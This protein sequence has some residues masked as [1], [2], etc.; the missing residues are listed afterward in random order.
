MKREEIKT[1]KD[2]CKVIGRK[3]RTYKDKHLNLYEQLSTI[4]AALN[5]I[6]NDNKPWTP[7]FDYYY[8]YSW[9]Y[10]EDEYN[11]T[12]GLFY[13]VSRDRLGSSPAASVGTS[14]KIK[15]REDG[16]YIMENFEELLQDWFWGD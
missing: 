2:A 7:K 12:A 16:N 10:R 11:K 15:E 8:I 3:P 5:F 13:L 6:S 1:Y 4:T 14:L 9:L